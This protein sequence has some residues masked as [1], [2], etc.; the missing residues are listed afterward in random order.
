MKNIY[1]IIKLFVL[2]S[3]AVIAYISIVLLSYES[4]YYCNDKNCL[5]FVETIKGRDLVVKVY[6]KRI[7]SRLQMKNSSYMEFYPEFIPYF[8]E[9]DNGRFIVHSDSEPK[10]AIGDM[11]N[12]RF[13]LSGYE[14]CGTP[15]YKLN[16]YMI[17]F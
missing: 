7:Y 5:T 6:D 8:E 3:F 10:I 2:C 4:Y 16:Y 9:D 14:C 15:F 1:F 12:I 11:S 17:I 13:V